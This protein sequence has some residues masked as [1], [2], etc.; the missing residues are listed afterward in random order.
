M[1]A[2]TSSVPAPSPVSSI[3]QKYPQVL[4]YRL[5]RLLGGGGFS[6]VFK[7]VNPDNPK[8][9]EAAVKV[10][11]YAPITSKSSARHPADRQAL[12][13]EVQIHGVLKHI[14]VLEF[15]GAD[16][17]GTASRPAG[18]SVPGLYMV[19]EYASGG[20]LFDK[21]AP[22]TGVPEDLAQYY[23]R[24]LIAGMQYIHSQGITHRDIKPE[25]LLL[26]ALGDLKIADFGLCSVYKYKGKERS[27]KGACG[28]L[29]YIAPEMNGQP[30]KGEG[31]DVWSAGV[32]LFALLVGN[33]PWD[34][35]TTRSPEY[36]AY[37]TGELLQYDPWTRISEQPLDL[38]K[39][40]LTPRPE[41]RISLAEIQQHAWF[42]RPNAFLQGGVSIEEKTGNLVQALMENMV[43]A[44][45][46][47]LHTDGAR[48]EVIDMPAA[49][50]PGAVTV[51]SS[52]LEEMDLGAPSAS[53]GPSITGDERAK[54]FAMSQQLPGR[55]L[56]TMTQN[57]NST[58]F[59]EVWAGMTQWADIAGHAQ[60]FSAQTTRFFCA[61]EPG[62]LVPHL[63]AILQQ[64]R[65]QTNVY[66][67]TPHR[68]Q[69]QHLLDMDN[70]IEGFSTLTQEP[71]K[72]WM[73]VFGGDEGAVGDG[74]DDDDE[75]AGG[76]DEAKG[77]PLGARLHIAL[78]D[79]RKCPLAGNIYIDALP[80]RGRPSPIC[81]N[82]KKLQI[83]SL[84]L[85]NRSSGSPLEWRKLFAT[86]VKSDTV[87][88]LVVPM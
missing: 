47:H 67:L 38:L 43:K 56:A 77:R 59:Q 37:L 82:G 7:G 40:M 68:A 3:G 14:N 65:A 84:V 66:T 23:F 85:M 1:A 26:S 18:I 80:L 17:L 2:P 41:K 20:D 46:L 63:L 75:L 70:I 9:K 74:M 8:R 88:Q 49:T 58:Q 79:R 62:E 28:S 73:P 13:K 12:Q 61:A 51:S 48:A 19:L 78:S 11:S 16:E 52:G 32:V 10:V 31:V 71:Q 33:T 44:G 76:S 54:R 25:N 30:Y 22:D 55:R 4:G 69:E 81:V 15:V 57:P 35:P 36:E 29:P 83:K 24:Q 34:E 6:K 86:I 60:R 45:D 39:A 72:N 5:T 87:K 27:L 42:N 50:Q 64:E 53:M 21:I